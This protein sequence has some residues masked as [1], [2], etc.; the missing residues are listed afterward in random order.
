M[1]LNLVALQGALGGAV[2]GFLLTMTGHEG[3]AALIIG[4]AAAAYAV[5]VVLLA[6][7]FGALGVSLATLTAYVL[8]AV[9]LGIYVQRRLGINVL[10]IW[11]RGATA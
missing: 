2:G 6:P 8:R 7:R 9:W 1:V 4:A 10:R 11:D 3:V 5:L